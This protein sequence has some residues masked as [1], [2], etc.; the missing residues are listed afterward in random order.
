[1]II[2]DDSDENTLTNWTAVAL[3]VLPLALDSG[4]SYARNA[5]LQAAATKYVFFVDDDMLF[6]Q[7][8]NVD[9]LLKVLEVSDFDIAATAEAGEALL[10]SS[11]GLLRAENGTL[12]LSSGSHGE[13]NGCLHVDL[14]PAVFLARRKVIARVGW[15]PQ[16]KLGVHEEFFLRALSARVRILSCRYAEVLHNQRLQNGADYDSSVMHKRKRVYDFFRAAL[17]KHD[18]QRFVSFGTSVVLIDAHPTY[19]H[20]TPSRASFYPPGMVL[21][22][23]FLIVYQRRSIFRA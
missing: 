4:L 7:A 14:T 22:A 18:L 13:F 2:S 20:V 8:S 6:T 3:R 23:V 21:G 11:H 15:D 19:T 9:V 12:E 10:T 17:K 1:M 16:L 5:L